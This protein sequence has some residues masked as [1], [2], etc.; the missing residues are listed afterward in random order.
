ML[1]S[2]LSDEQ[3]RKRVKSI[4]IKPI[5]LYIIRY[6]SLTRKYALKSVIPAVCRRESNLSENGCPTKNIGH[7]EKSPIF[8]SLRDPK[9][10]VI[11]ACRVAPGDSPRRE[12]FRKDSGQA[13]MTNK[14]TITFF[15]I[16]SPKGAAIS[17]SCDCFVVQKA[18]GLLA[19][20]S[21]VIVHN[22]Y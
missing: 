11:P 1:T 14:R 16:A 7:D 8:M 13:E 21:Q 5:N 10:H 20:T 12:S 4:T 17:C 9:I 18:L 15:V 2:L 6:Q 19:M 22:Q 3:E